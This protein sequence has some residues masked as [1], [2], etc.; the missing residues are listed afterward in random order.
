MPVPQSGRSGEGPRRQ[1]R[2]LRR[3]V[4][5]ARPDPGVEA[6]EAAA[7]RD[8]ALTASARAARTSSSAQTSLARLDE[9]L[10]T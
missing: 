1:S 10:D 4:R 9:V 8:R 6:Y 7:D 5:R 2:V 3:P